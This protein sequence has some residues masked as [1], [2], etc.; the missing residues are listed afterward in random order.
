MIAA[1]KMPENWGADLPKWKPGDK[2]IA[3]R[4]AGGEALNGLAKR[5]PISS[6]VRLI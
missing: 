3:T 1:G 4:V 5:S 2:P 6:A